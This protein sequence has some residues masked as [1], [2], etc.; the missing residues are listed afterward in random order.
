MINS[1]VLGPG[2][3]DDGA[4][5]MT[6]RGTD[7]EPQLQP[8]WSS[9]AVNFLLPKV[10]AAAKTEEQSPEAVARPTATAREDV[11]LSPCLILYLRL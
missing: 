8:K 7:A 2:N 10:V 9:G 11:A 3:H 6:R 1:R 4:T 5:S